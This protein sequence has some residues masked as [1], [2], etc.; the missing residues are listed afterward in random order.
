MSDLL[1][2]AIIKDF[3]PS[4][5]EQNRHL[6]KNKNKIVRISWHLTINSLTPGAHKKVIHTWTNLTF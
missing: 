6:N 5:S 2:A 1:E 4:E 3:F